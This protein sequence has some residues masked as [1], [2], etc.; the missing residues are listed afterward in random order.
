M[1]E[2]LALVSNPMLTEVLNYALFNGGKRIR[3]LLTVL[4]GKL[5][6]QAR[7]VM[8]DSVYTLSLAFEYL[9]AASLLHD[10]VID[11]ADQR[12]GQAA[13]NRV[14]G[15]SAVILAGDYLHSR[16][17]FLAGTIG[18]QGCLAK[19][20][21][22]TA[23]MVES[24]FIQMKNA[25]EQDRSESSYFDV[26]DGKTAALI[27]AA[28]EVGAIQAGADQDQQQALSRFG[29]SLGIAFQIVDDLL[30][31]LGEPGKTGKV[32]G[33][34]FQE[35]KMTLPLI[36]ALDRANED[37]RRILTNLLDSTPEQRMASVSQAKAIIEKNEGFVKA[38]SVAEELIRKATAGL[39]IFRDCRE[40][41]I[42]LGLGMYVLQR[43]K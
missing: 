9:H 25:Q 24:E 16:A 2:D 40:K 27:A 4:S 23:S 21:Q 35:G 19:I 14:W 6:C 28:C 11:Y 1:A 39:C 5:C 8:D 32:V 17:M 37:D 18:L 3:P 31:Y 43:D 30:D 42:L 22:A 38:H 12:R 13:A 7:G 41:E 20:C 26:L 15:N 10:D 36:K 34:D 29:A 33:N